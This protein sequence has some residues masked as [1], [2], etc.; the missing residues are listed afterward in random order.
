MKPNLDASKGM[1]GQIIKKRWELSFSALLLDYSVLPTALFFSLPP[2]SLPLLLSAFELFDFSLLSSSGCWFWSSF[3]G[4][5][6]LTV[7]AEDGLSFL[8]PFLSLRSRHKTEW[9]RLTWRKSSN[10]VTLCLRNRA[11]YRARR[12][13]WA[14]LV[15]WPNFYVCRPLFQA[16]IS[17]TW[18]P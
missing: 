4:L 12:G 18:S 14:Q 2:L 1:S 11:H 3:W 7:G 13:E 9:N 6:V 10:S 5:S 17:G 16:Q 15:C 8:W